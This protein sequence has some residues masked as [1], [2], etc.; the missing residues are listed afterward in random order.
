MARKANKT[1]DIATR[2]VVLQKR[3]ER[4][5]IS[6]WQL[7]INQTL[8]QTPKWIKLQEMYES[9]MFDAHLQSQVSLRKNKTLGLPWR[10]LQGEKELDTQ[11][12]NDTIKAF[13]EQSLDSLYYGYSIVLLNTA[14]GSVTPIDR[15]NI[16]PRNHLLYDN[17][18]LG[19]ALPY[20]ELPEYGKTLLEF[21]HGD[22]GLLVQAAPHV[23][24]KRFAQSCWSE[25]CEIYGMPPRYIK[26][27]TNDKELVQKY[28]QALANIGSGASYVLDLD[29]EMG[30]ASTNATNGE[31]YA[32]LINLCKSEISLLICGA[33]VGQ[34]TMYGSNAKE[35]SSQDL[36]QD[37]IDADKEYV[38]NHINGV[39][40][41]ALE[42]LGLPSNC[43]FEF[44][45]QEDNSE[46]FN[47][48]IQAAAY[49]DIDPEWFKEK[50][51]IEVTAAKQAGFGLKQ[52]ET[53]FF[54]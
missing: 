35:Q 20:R 43:S 9:L 7:A 36:L 6:D 12:F 4:K 53:D 28:E 39:V 33:M 41:P 49:F 44:I 51:G 8:A 32:N 15:R 18:L 29:D 37:I 22:N 25:L 21:N 5:D 19:S 31:V 10:L 40:L 16:D 23:L 3:F 42:A 52:N 54:G 1:N 48:T 47:Q 11:E 50:F 26:T 13:I 27:N 34:D 38:T 30:F 46:L 14:D 24:F 17:P 45:Q 2:L